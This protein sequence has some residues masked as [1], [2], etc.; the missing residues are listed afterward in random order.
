MAKLQIPSPETRQWSGIFPGQ[1][2]GSIW[3]AKSIDLERN[4]GKVGLADSYSDIQNSGQGGFGNLTVPIAF[5]RS[6]AD[7]TDRWWANAGKLFKTSGSNP[8]TGWAEDAIASTP[9]A[10]LYDLIDFVG[11]LICPTSTDLSR[12]SA[13]TWTASWWQ[14]TLGQAA[15]TANPHRFFILAG[16]LC[17]TDGRLVHRYD[18]TIVGKDLTIPVGFRGEGGVVWRD[19]AFVFGANIVGQEAE[20]F[21]WDGIS[22]NYTGRFPVGDTEVLCMFIIDVPYAVTKKGSLKKW[23]GSGF[24]QVEVGG[25]PVQFPTVEVQGQINA[26]HPNGVSVT[27]GIAKMLVDFGVITNDRAISG[28]WNFDA[29]KGNLYNCGSVRNTGAKDYAQH[30][31]AGVGALQQTFVSQGLYLAGAQVY[32]DY[33]G[34]TKYGIFS[35]DEASTSNQGYFITPKLRSSDIRRYWRLLLPTM[36]RMDNAD[37]RIRFAVRTQDSNVLPAYETATWTAAN[38]FTAANTDIAAGDFVEVLAGDNAGALARI[39]AISGTTVTIDRSLYSSTASSRVRYIRFTDIG[40]IANVSVQ[41]EIFRIAER[42][43]WLQI[44]CEL[45]GTETSPLIE[46]ILLNFD[47]IPI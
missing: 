20:I 27:E 23:T 8:E 4:R 37:D 34:T 35:S 40:N 46:S 14:T 44:L 1:D 5:V 18:G 2:F 24:E 21:T 9:S 28:F 29:K 7:N 43:P 10:P 47:E 32:T 25:L 26:L 31:L 3:S 36:R 30:E 38:Q 13:G 41:T 16:A 22:D 12:L 19:T 33:S 45:R 6:S 39:T 11:A 42:S 15:L 17:F